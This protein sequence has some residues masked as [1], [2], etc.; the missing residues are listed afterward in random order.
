MQRQATGAEARDVEEIVDE[1]SH[2]IGDRV[3][4][5]QRARASLGLV[6]RGAAL[7]RSPIRRRSR[8][9]VNGVFELVRRD[10]D[11]LVAA[12]DGRR[13]SAS[14]AASIIMLTAET[15]MEHCTQHTARAASP[16]ANT[17]ARWRCRMPRPPNHQQR[18]GGPALPET[19]RR[20]DQQRR[21]PGSVPRTQH[22]RLR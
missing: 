7:P 6:A 12:P 2:A 9:A 14:A 17:P 18:R 21:R 15:A 10:G 3:G 13:R 1:A 5:G 20:P 8:S 19:Q 16:R 11:E 22:D 4:G